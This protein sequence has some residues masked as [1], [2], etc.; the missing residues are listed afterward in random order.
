LERE[1]QKLDALNH[2]LLRTLRLA[3]ER[4]GAL[5]LNA[6]TLPSTRLMRLAEAWT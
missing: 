2:E 1:T 5:V 4:I 6:R 3:K